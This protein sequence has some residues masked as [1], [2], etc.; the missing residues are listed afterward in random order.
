MCDNY[1]IK[2]VSVCCDFLPQVLY[3]PYSEHNNNIVGYRHTGNRIILMYNTYFQ[4]GFYIY[5][6]KNVIF[7]SVM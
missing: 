2:F 5:K 1:A 4:K 3:T 6:K 7:N